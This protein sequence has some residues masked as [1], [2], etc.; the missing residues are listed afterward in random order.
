MKTTSAVSTFIVTDTRKGSGRVFY[1]AARPGFYRSAN[2]EQINDGTGGKSGPEWTDKRE[3]ALK[4]KSHR[5]AAIVANKC[6]SAEIVEI[7]A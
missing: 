3:F 1:V 4:F 5:A 2:G 7:P 6:A